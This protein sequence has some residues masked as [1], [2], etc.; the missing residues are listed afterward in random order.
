MKLFELKKSSKDVKISFKDKIILIKGPLG[1]VQYKLNY[2]F[3]SKSKEFF[4][5]KKE[6]IFLKKLIKSLVRSVVKGWFLEIILNGIGYKCFKENDKVSFD[7]GY[8]LLVN[9][10]PSE[11]VKIKIFKNKIVLFSIDK[12][13]LYQT[14]FSLVRLS[15]KD[16]YKGKGILL[17]DTV[18]KLKKKK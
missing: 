17:K 3:N 9:Y 6:I 15:A 12:N 14:A 18:L 7:L 2:N 10:V 1:E 13:L 4:I 11:K 16:S 5:S 8:S